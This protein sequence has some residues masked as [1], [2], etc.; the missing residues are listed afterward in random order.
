MHKWRMA[1]LEQLAFWRNAG[2]G[3]AAAR[4]IGT[5]LSAGILGLLGARKGTTV[6]VSMIGGNNF[7]YDEVIVPPQALR[8]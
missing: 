7:I 4:L 8:T 5:T 6:G 1:Q 3:R 2:V